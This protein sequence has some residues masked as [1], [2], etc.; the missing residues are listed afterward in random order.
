LQ[1]DVGHRDFIDKI[2]Q[3]I[4]QNL[5]QLV[6]DEQGRTLTPEEAE[7]KI[8]EEIRFTVGT[9]DDAEE[10]TA[11][12]RSTIRKAA[13]KKTEG[14]PLTEEEEKLAADKEKVFT[15]EVK[16]QQ[17]TKQSTKGRKTAQTAET[18]T[19]PEPLGSKD[20]RG[21]DPRNLFGLFS[22]DK[23][24]IRFRTNL[25]NA[26][27]KSGV[28]GVFRA[29]T[30]T[31]AKAE[32]IT[33]AYSK[34]PGTQLYRSPFKENVTIY[35]SGQPIGIL[36]PADSVWLDQ[37]GKRSVYNLTA[38][39]YAA[40]TGNPTNTYEQFMNA[41][42]AYQRAYN[43]LR[44]SIADSKGVINKKEAGIL[45]FLDGLKNRQGIDN[46][47]GAKE[48]VEQNIGKIEDLDGLKE[49]KAFVTK[50]IEEVQGQA[51]GVDIH[52]IQKFFTLSINPGARV[53]NNNYRKDTVL[54]DLNYKP[55][56]TALVSFVDV[57]AVNNR[58]KQTSERTS[59]PAIVNAAELT[60]K[61]KDDLNSFLQANLSHFQNNFNRY[62]VIVPIN[63]QYTI[64]G[65][66][67][68]RNAETTEDQR[69]A[70]YNIVHNVAAGVHDAEQ[71]GTV[72]NE[73]NETYFL[74]NADRTVK[75]TFT[76][77]SFT[78]TGDMIVNINNPSQ[79][80]YK[81]VL[82][83]KQSLQETKNF[84][85]V[86]TKIQAAVYADERKDKGLANLHVIF[87]ENSL[88]QQ[89]PH[90]TKVTS[91]N[92]V[93]DKIKLATTADVFENYTIHFNPKTEAATQTEPKQPE[94]KPVE[95]T[96]EST[97][98]EVST[99]EQIKE[100]KPSTIQ[101]EAV[102]IV[103]TY[104][105]EEDFNYKIHDK[106]GNNLGHIDI[107]Y[108]KTSDVFRVETVQVTE[109]RKGTGLSTYKTLIEGLP[110]PLVSGEN[111]SDE[112]KGLWTKLEK[113]GY[114]TYD[115]ENNRY[116]SKL[117]E[118]AKSEQ[119]P[120]EN[121]QEEPIKTEVE[122][123]WKTGEF[124][125]LY[126]PTEEFDWFKWSEK[127]TDDY[128]EIVGEKE[129][130]QGYDPEFKPKAK[131]YPISEIIKSI[132]K[133]ISKNVAKHLNT[134]PPGLSFNENIADS[135]PF[136]KEDLGLGKNR[137]IKIT[138]KVKL[139]RSIDSYG[140][141]RPMVYDM[142]SGEVIDLP[143]FWEYEQV[144]DDE[145]GRY[146]E[147]GFKVL[148]PDFIKKFYENNPKRYL[149]LDYDED[150]Q[151]LYILVHKELHSTE[152]K[153]AGLLSQL[154][155]KAGEFEKGQE[156]QYF[157][158]KAGENPDFY[159]KK[160][161]EAITNQLLAQISSEK[162]EK[163]VQDM[164]DIGGT[165][166]PSIEILNREL[167]RREEYTNKPEPEVTN[168]E[169]LTDQ[170]PPSE[171]TLTHRTTELSVLKD[172][173]ISISDEFIEDKNGE[174]VLNPNPTY[175]YTVF[176]GGYISEDFDTEEE[177][178]A[179]ID[180]Y[181]SLPYENINKGTVFE[182]LKLPSNRIEIDDKYESKDLDK[183]N[184]SAFK[185]VEE[186]KRNIYDQIKKLGEKKYGNKFAYQSF[187]NTK[188][189]VDN[190]ISDAYYYPVVYDT[191]TKT[192]ID[193]PEFYSGNHA[194]GNKYIS[195][196][197]KN[198]DPRFLLL[199]ASAE[200]DS[201]DLLV[202]VGM[203]SFEGTKDT[204]EPAAVIEGQYVQ[205]T[206]A[207]QAK[208]AK[209][210]SNQGFISELE[211]DGKRFDKLTEV[212]KPA[213]AG[214]YNRSLP[215]ET[216]VPEAVYNIGDKVVYGQ[217]QKEYTITGARRVAKTKE[218]RAGEDVLIGSDVIYSTEQGVDI[219]ENGITAKARKTPVERAQ[220]VKREH[221]HRQRVL[222]R[223]ANH[224]QRLF[225]QIKVEVGYFDFNAPARFYKGVVQVNVGFENK[226]SE[227][228]KKLHQTL[229]GDVYLKRETVAHEF[230]H[231]FIAALKQSNPALY[232]NL[233][234]ELQKTKP[235]IVNYINELVK[236][237]LYEEATK[238]DEGLAIYLGN[239]I[240]KAFDKNGVL[241]QEYAK[242]R[243][244]NLLARFFD[245]LQD[246]WNLITGKKRPVSVENFVKLANSDTS[247]RTDAL[248]AQIVRIDALK[249]LY[250]KK[251]NRD[252]KVTI[253]A[254][255]REYNKLGFEEFAKKYNIPTQT[256]NKL[257]NDIEDFTEQKGTGKFKFEIRQNENSGVEFDEGDDNV[258]VYI[259]PALLTD[260]SSSAILEA[261]GDRI[262]DNELSD[263]YKQLVRRNFY[264]K[265]T[266][267]EDK[268]IGVKQINPFMRLQDVS[269]FLVTQL[270]DPT[271]SIKYTGEELSVIDEL[272]AYM[273]LTDPE[274]KKFRERIVKRLEALKD[275]SNRRL[276][277]D[278]LQ[279][280]Y[281]VLS[282]LNLDANDVDFILGYVEQ[283]TAAIN[284][285]WRKY[286]EIRQDLEDK[287]KLDPFK[288]TRLS[289]ELE[290]IK[291][292]ISFYDDVSGI[293][294]NFD[295]MFD[296]NQL[297]SFRKATVAI[298]RIKQSMANTAAELA[299]EWLYPYIEKNNE[300]LAKQGY[301]DSKYTVTR[302][303]FKNNLL[304]G[305][306]KDL[307][308]LTFQLGAVVNSRDP[309]NAAFANTVADTIH[310][311]H[312]DINNEIQD[313]IVE[314][315]KWLKRTGISAFDEKAQLEYYQKHYLR[316]AKIW[317]VVDYD[318]LKN[319]PIYGYVEKTA[320]HQKYYTDQ[321]DDKVRLYK[322]S[323]PMPRTSDE[324]AE[325]LQK[326]DA[327]RKSI[328]DQHLNPE[329]AKLQNDPYFKELEFVYERQNLKYGKD[330]LAHG[331]VPQLY[332]GDVLKK[333]KENFKKAWAEGDLKDSAKK[334]ATH[335]SDKLASLQ[336]DNKAINLDGTVYRIMNKELANLKDD[337]KVEKNLQVSMVDFI[338]DASRYA[339]LRDIQWNAE[340]L[341]M[342]IEGNTKFS[343]E[344]RKIGAEDLIAG[345]RDRR[346]LAQAKEKLKELD[347]LKAKGDPLFNQQEYDDL[348]ARIAKGVQAR[349]VW[350]KFVPRLKKGQ[351]D[352]LNKQLTEMLNDVFYGEKEFA[353]NIK[354]G[355]QNISLNKVGH[356]VGMYTSI[357]SM[358][359]NRV[360]GVANVLQG[361][362]QM[363]IEALGGKHYGLKDVGLGYKALFC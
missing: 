290:V 264:Q 20:F 120:V 33:T 89:I 237:G 219:M 198:N 19:A 154:K 155:E 139:A 195:E 135:T 311:N 337:D 201:I 114:A 171:S 216:G 335:V 189:G 353:S 322:Q 93:E 50:R 29:L 218:N 45:N 112:A 58:G 338:I 141:Y 271:L 109:P 246:V 5:D 14:Q 316:K 23:N 49:I 6:A 126:I 245:W 183:N 106:Q 238:F 179:F 297:S 240:T 22:Q 118:A 217:D 15:N 203:P 212:L 303:E 196:F 107:F 147:D 318:D 137:D 296:T 197:Y 166:N 313:F 291:Q 282:K 63:G 319:E 234:K 275:T 272:E 181:N 315:N 274:A 178:K 95:P 100:V 288:V 256:L 243:K 314:Y 37:D 99:G 251:H 103:L 340:N 362:S 133:E 43:A 35:H 81:Q 190:T 336:Q 343:V 310:L 254:I 239:E 225:P 284:L 215:V 346:A 320:L 300:Y 152:N 295:E 124:A 73:V 75:Q 287:D 101:G 250:T 330:A 90:D 312:V 10:T 52:E 159:I 176:K 74:A 16:I 356:T 226:L 119:Q 355:D 70:F 293:Y 140:S 180:K 192:L 42:R 66:I 270:S 40:A 289:K 77:I 47:E 194:I 38:D 261:Y 125:D 9:P 252:I 220:Q 211:F 131:N 110:K 214:Q 11:D 65:A 265:G 59:E 80:V 230:M 173:H 102:D 72:I 182:N 352:R 354:I 31:Y 191:V 160:Y 188:F 87:D 280:Q 207:G 169:D 348:K 78:T 255:N 84:N 111:M 145:L 360:A 144:G 138:K 262:K 325:Q 32:P 205:Y 304:Y 233:V 86:V 224:F 266:G 34:I 82:I 317:T 39:E 305:T 25:Y 285:A 344:P 307:G 27:F 199:N 283:G 324:W 4:Q 51:A 210:I 60:D 308:F 263:E 193:L 18:K 174:Y 116:I 156:L 241:D 79:K 8:E 12:E 7:V 209:V 244:N 24:D 136:T 128:F 361:D 41:I 249:D 21:A 30:A 363:W 129:S 162:L 227:Q 164:L 97:T 323:L 28:N 17:L 213:T 2:K 341:R 349:S 143:G 96:P 56:G 170:D 69:T 229:P 163:N 121:K 332:R 339:G 127:G 260:N 221:L 309:I 68:A 236:G 148:T 321:I 26:I 257:I 61:Q 232:N 331:I 334:L 267:V 357:A 98:P 326:V 186:D 204:Y 132:G 259:D 83:A 328:I 187:E 306:N 57:I 146:V 117:P 88:K 278:V 167:D 36:R 206:E 277:N 165:E 46:Y 142:E 258:K 54:R 345:V 223:I 347:K 327:Y 91:L 134:T 276:S 185:Y 64:L 235:E 71:L 281:N 231:P 342:L 302:E 268:N 351:T 222:N 158:D 200:G 3:Q 105:S 92:Q 358:A 150:E 53:Q 301:T 202:S 350:D 48:Y 253:K 292:L 247:S 273:E 55:A 108:D 294:N 298:D 157:I 113:Q 172:I 168:Y 67:A 149:L 104:S 76:T 115:K 329:Y 1:T 175:T 153:P 130:S 242:Q 248:R 161:G 122:Q 286:N 94:P 333:A 13:K 44:D 123:K 184:Y 62:I 279:L 299:T 177:A 85:D 359:F 151:N 228:S 269:D 208:F